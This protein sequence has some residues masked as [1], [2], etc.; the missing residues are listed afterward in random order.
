[1]TKWVVIALSF[2]SRLLFAPIVRMWVRKGAKEEVKA[3]IVIENVAKEEKARVE[4]YREK[5]NTDGLSDSD[6]V[7]RLRRRD[8]DWS[9]L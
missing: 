8:D 6:L 2:L 1:M 4:A 3:E 9:R 5:K 7:D